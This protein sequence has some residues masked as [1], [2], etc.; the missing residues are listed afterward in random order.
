V[1]EQEIVNGCMNYQKAAQKALYK[2]YAP[3]AYAICLRYLKD[4]DDAKDI[5]Q[6]GFIKV[7]T[8]IQ[9]FRSEGSLE[10]WVK[11]II[12]NTALNSIRNNKSFV[13]SLNSLEN[14]IPD[15]TGEIEY[16]EAEYTEEELLEQ[17]QL[18][19][20]NYRIIFNLVCFEEY[21]HK[22]I[23]EQLSIS[24]ESSRVRLNRA[25]KILQERLLKIKEKRLK[26]SN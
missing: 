15:T 23:A 6:E 26:T 2:L 11:R 13:Q 20:D 16:D 24:E 3:V 8:G 18:L 1:T 7:Y 17:I 9:K 19:P 14:D 22:M 5:M 10:G 12:T 25:R 4:S 21:S